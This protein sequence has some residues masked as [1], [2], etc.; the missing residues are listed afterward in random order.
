MDCSSLQCTAFSL[1]WPCLSGGTGSSVCS[2]T[3]T[4]A[5]EAELDEEAAKYHQEDW[6]FLAQEKGTSTSKDDLVECLKNVTVALQNSGIKLPSNNSKSPSAPPLPPAYA[7]SVIAGLDPPPGPSPPPPSEIVSPLQKALKQ[8]Q[9]LGE[10][11]ADISYPRVT[12]SGIDEKTGKRSYRDGTGPLDI[13]FCDKHLSIGIGIDTPWTLCRARVASVYNINNA[14]ATLLWDWAPGGKPDFP[15]YRGQHPPIFSVNTAQVYQTE[16]WKL[17][18][19]FG[20]GNSLYLQ[21]NISGNKYAAPSSRAKAEA[22]G[23]RMSTTAPAGCRSDLDPRYYRLCDKK[24]AWGIVLEALAGVGAVASVAF[25]IALLALICKVQ[26]SNKRKLLPTQF[27]FLL[28][29]LGVFG[30]TFAFLITL[31]GGTGPTRFFLFGVLFAL[32]FSCLLVHAFNLTKLV[33]GRQP[34]SMLVMLGLALGFS[35]VQDIIAIEYVVLT[36]NRT[37][38]NIFSEL[39]PPRRNEDFVMLLI[40]VL[41]LMALTFLTASFSFQGSFTAW[42]RHGAH[43]YLATILSIA[44]WVAWIT[45]LLVPTIG[46]Q[47]DDTI[48]SS[49]LVANGWVFLLAYIA[50]EFQLLTRQQ[51]P[52]DYPVEDAFCQPQFMKQSYG[53]V[54]RAYSQEGIIQGTEETGSTLYAPYS[55]HFQL[56]NRDSP[57]DFSIPRVQTRVSPYSDYEGRKDVS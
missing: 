32:C 13:P 25:M 29:V 16:L 9:R 18:A 14:D 48:L 43:I 50:P 56:Q 57:K 3:A 27:L 49:A 2:L 8:A 11:S 4:V 23:A 30:L 52:M 40:Y 51:N 38:A 55:T 41:F 10:V 24:A 15:E 28:G 26:D 45:L 33:R 6:G 36:M 31:D 12:I 17:L 22:S 37:N 1:Q 7:P 20:H 39:S 46:P 19:A 21:P 54:N 35:L 44:I 47:W 34:L 53:V 5:D 42:K